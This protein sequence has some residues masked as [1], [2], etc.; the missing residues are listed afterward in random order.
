MRR[1]PT[2]SKQYR[3]DH[4]LCPNCG[5]EAAPYYL[6]HKCRD[7]TALTRQLNRMVD[8][9]VLE[10]ERL[11]RG[12]GY[13]VNKTS[14][15]TLDDFVAYKAWIDLSPDDKRRRP[16]L[17]RRPI[18]LDETLI[19]IFQNAG[20]PLTIEEVVAAWGHL[21]SQRRHETLATD[22]TVIIKAQRKRDDRAA[23]RL[24]SL[25]RA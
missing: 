16:R 2:K 20:I 10:R 22:M 15:K 19:G 6:C 3:V 24:A 21:R 4:G 14:G 11:G 25:A 23:K 12:F 17:G 1:D 5:E 8:Q 13:S 7:L 18:D 9:G